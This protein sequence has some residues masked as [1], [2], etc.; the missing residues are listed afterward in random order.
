MD[1]NNMCSVN[2]EAL[3]DVV[4]LNQELYGLAL[5]NLYE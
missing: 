5:E 3:H 4:D 1:K 2:L